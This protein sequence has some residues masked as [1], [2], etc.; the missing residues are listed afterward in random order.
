MN[1]NPNQIK[2]KQRH[3]HARNQLLN[4]NQASNIKYQRLS[5]NNY[6][7]IKIVFDAKTKP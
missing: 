2:T 3:R 1:Q 5:T 7:L 6:D 4:N